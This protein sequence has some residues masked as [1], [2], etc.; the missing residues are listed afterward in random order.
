MDAPKLN[1]QR[2]QWA[3]GYLFPERYFAGRIP[4]KFAYPS[5]I[6]N[7]VTEVLY[8][9]G[10]A[11]NFT[12]LWNPQA[13]MDSSVPAL[14]QYTTIADAPPAD[15][16]ILQFSLSITPD[17]FPATGS[18]IQYVFS[19]GSWQ[20]G[21]STTG[22]F[23]WSA[24]DNGQ[25]RTTPILN[26][27]GFVL[28]KNFY[29]YTK[30]PAMTNMAQCRITAS[31]LSIE[32]LGNPTSMAGTIS[33]AAIFGGK[34]AL[35]NFNK[36]RTGGLLLH[37]TGPLDFRRYISRYR[38]QDESYLKFLTPIGNQKDA[39][40]Y[41]IHTINCPAESQFLIKMIRIVESVPLPTLEEYINPVKEPAIAL[42]IEDQMRI[43]GR[44]EHN[45]S[46]FTDLSIK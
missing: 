2:A 13:E 39:G 6:S 24:F 16:S 5:H 46:P 1:L 34:T 42:N 22:T 25:I 30:S 17:N 21:S 38:I 43:V 14:A 41:Y 45:A 33:R 40:P 18:Y 36:S 4:D 27:P 28:P 7:L 12:I 3:L 44:N 19:S 10:A 8:N 26:A 31:Y 32:Y 20:R 9:S 35:M 23:Q 15:V 29:F 37:Q 11:T